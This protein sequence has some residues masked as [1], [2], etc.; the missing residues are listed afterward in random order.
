MTKNDSNYPL[1]MDYLNNVLNRVIKKNNMPKIS[2][3]G[4]RHTHASLSFESGANVKDV[5]E[6]LGHTSIQITLDMYTHVKQKS[7]KNT[8]EKFAKFGNF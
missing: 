7:N 8:A 3:H 1:H 4:L 6:K 5:Q 2:P